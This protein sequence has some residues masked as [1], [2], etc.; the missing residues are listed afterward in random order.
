[1]SSCH[2]RTCPWAAAALPGEGGAWGGS[3]GA[4]PTFLG[5]TSSKP[6]KVSTTHWGS[7]HFGEP[8]Q[9]HPRALHQ[10]APA[11]QKRSYKNNVLL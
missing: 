8:I 5:E 7:P 3:H 1:M 2:P 11:L 4:E 10:I 6:S 9:S